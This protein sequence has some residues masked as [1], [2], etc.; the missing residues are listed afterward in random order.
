MAAG[1]K[2]GGRQKGSRNKKTLAREA[3]LRCVGAGSYDTDPLQFLLSVMSDTHMPLAMRLDAAV[4]AAPFCHP[5]LRPV[6]H[7]GERKGKSALE[8]LLGEIDGTTRG[9]PKPH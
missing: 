8:E 4:K 6:A 7:V 5:K 9:I 1:R 3:I 2:T